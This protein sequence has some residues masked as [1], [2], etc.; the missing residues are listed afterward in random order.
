MLLY[1]NPEEFEFDIIEIAE[2]KC[3][4]SQ[5][6]TYIYIHKKSRLIDTMFSERQLKVSKLVHF[7]YYHFINRKSRNYL[8]FLRFVPL[9]HGG[10]HSQAF[11]TKVKHRPLSAWKGG[12]RA[13]VGH[14]A[15]DH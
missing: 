10:Y 3:I 8:N 6:P 14:V 4:P 7:I 2:T 15:S 5:L 13:R 9:E 1:P 12:P 11:L